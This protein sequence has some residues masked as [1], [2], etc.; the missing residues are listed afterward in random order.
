MTTMFNVEDVVESAL[1]D[2]GAFSVPAGRAGGYVT[3]NASDYDFELYAA[4]LLAEEEGRDVTNV[5]N[6]DEDTNAII[7]MT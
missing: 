5:S 4:N 7:R 6:E 3:E 1:M 2:L